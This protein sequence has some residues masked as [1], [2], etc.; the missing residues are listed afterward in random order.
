MATERSYSI[1]RNERTGKGCTDAVVES[2]LSWEVASS[3]REQLQNAEIAAHPH[4]S[5]WTRA[6]Y[7][8]RLEM[9]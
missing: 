4:K 8:I 7:W 5:S 3:K 2:G 9:R 1:L 6:I